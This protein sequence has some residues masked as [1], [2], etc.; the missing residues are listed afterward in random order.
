MA[1]RVRMCVSMDDL[2]EGTRDVVFECKVL[3]HYENWD[4]RK[5]LKFAYL[6]CDVIDR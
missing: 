5:Q 1:L 3:S 6:H 4:P 2:S